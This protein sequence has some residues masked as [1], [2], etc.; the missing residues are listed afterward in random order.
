[1][2]RRQQ[3]RAWNGHFLGFWARLN[4]ENIPVIPAWLVRSN[5][6]DPRR[7]P[8][9]LIWRDKRHSGEIKE[10]VR[11][12]R[13][14][15]PQDSHARD[16]HVELKRTDGSVTVL[17]VV[18]RMLPRNG[19]RALFLHCSYCNTARRYV[20]GW[21]WDC[22]SGWS[23]RVTR[24]SWR[25]RLCAQLRYSSEGGYLRPGA[26]FRAFG[27]LPRPDLWL[28]YVFTSPEEAAEASYEKS[29]YLCR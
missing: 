19:G 25:C 9:L 4:C 27:N 29:E 14:V 21:E 3:G 28:P 8:Y 17:R 16:S 10:A 24:I 12:A 23:N 13:Y 5:I 11:L 20:Y 26:M 6:N 22:F 1:V 15:D 7:I 2:Y 18:W